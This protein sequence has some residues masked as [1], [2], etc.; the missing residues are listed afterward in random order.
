MGTSMNNFSDNSPFRP[1]IPA[2]LLASLLLLSYLVLREYL[3][4]LIWAFIL[5]YV[6]W[7]IYQRLRTQLKQQA[8]VSAALMTLL[9]ATV[10]LLTI[11]WLATLLQNEL[12]TAYQYL[13]V[14]FTQEKYQLP[15]ATRNIPWFGDYLQDGICRMGSLARS[16]KRIAVFA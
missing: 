10:I 7:P 8:T 1:L 12:K 3:L 16:T 15:K 11:Y 6:T 5:A 4:S 14:T 9:I 2:I 13:I